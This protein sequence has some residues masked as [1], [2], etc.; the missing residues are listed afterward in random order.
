M[1]T[2]E[3][4]VVT[5]KALVLENKLRIQVNVSMILRKNVIYITTQL[6]NRNASVLRMEVWVKILNNL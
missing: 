3:E 2:P 1:N 6:N 4:L 5:P